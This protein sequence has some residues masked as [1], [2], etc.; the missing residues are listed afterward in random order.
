MNAN[1]ETLNLDQSGQVE[2][3]DTAENELSG[4]DAPLSFRGI[5]I[6]TSL[7]ICSVIW[8]SSLFV[9]IS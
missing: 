6:L 2:P 7:L 3:Y 4:P 9:L 5:V 1:S 8:T